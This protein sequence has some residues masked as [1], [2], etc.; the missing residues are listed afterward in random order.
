MTPLILTK[1][2]GL[3]QKREQ[4]HSNRSIIFKIDFLTDEFVIDLLLSTLTH[5]N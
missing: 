1:V 2:F 3:Y 4:K 5:V